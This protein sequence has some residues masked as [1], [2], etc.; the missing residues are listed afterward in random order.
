MGP[1][2]SLRNVDQH[3]AY[4]Y[5]K[6]QFLP[7]G[8]PNFDWNCIISTFFFSFFSDS[9]HSW[10]WHD[11]AHSQNAQKFDSN[12][13]KF[14]EIFD[15]ISIF[16]KKKFVKLTQ[17]CPNWLKFAQIWLK[18]DWNLPKFDTF[19]NWLLESNWFLLS[20]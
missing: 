4:R 5:E 1:S 3:H 11:H 9:W 16:K 8:L 12:L 6:C 14:E 15:K 20:K 7:L 19:V 2:P 17:I 18:F 13:P 10:W